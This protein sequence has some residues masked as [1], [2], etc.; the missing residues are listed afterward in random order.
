MIINLTS[1]ADTLA[2]AGCG[3]LLVF[4]LLHSRR[5]LG[6]LYV[7]MGWALL[8]VAIRS[9]GDMVFVERWSIVVAIC[10]VIILSLYGL[11]QARRHRVPVYKPIDQRKRG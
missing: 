11:L 6:F 5:L 3:T 2:L 4:W 10:S 9:N 8:I 7:L 1:I